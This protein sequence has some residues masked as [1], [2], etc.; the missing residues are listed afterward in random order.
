[1]GSTVLDIMDSRPLDPRIAR[2]DSVLREPEG[3]GDLPL[4]LRTFIEIVKRRAAL[5]KEDSTPSPASVLYTRLLSES[6]AESIERVISNW[7]AE[8]AQQGRDAPLV[9]SPLRAVSLEM[10]R[11]VQPRG[12]G[13]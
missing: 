12:N 2:P 3:T 11:R 1:M 9:S 7:V 8:Q 13:Q 4:V 10:E 6:S 5:T